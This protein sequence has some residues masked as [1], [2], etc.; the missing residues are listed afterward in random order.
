MGLCCPVMQ[1]YHTLEISGYG[2]IQWRLPLLPFGARALKHDKNIYTT[3]LH[4][5]LVP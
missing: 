5:R 4:A 2:S 1:I 3:H